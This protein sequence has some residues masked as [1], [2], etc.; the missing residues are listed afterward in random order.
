MLAP[1]NLFRCYL[2]EQ[3]PITR[4]KCCLHSQKY[5]ITWTKLVFDLSMSDIPLALKTL[6]ECE[7]TTFTS[8]PLLSILGGLFTLFKSITLRFFPTSTSLL[9]RLIFP[10]F[11]CF[12]VGQHIYFFYSIS[13]NTCAWLFLHIKKKMQFIDYLDQPW[14][15]IPLLVGLNVFLCRFRCFRYIAHHWPNTFMSLF[16]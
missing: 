16:H 6:G 3:F 12:L 9:P 11:F 13:S 5:V 4:Q 8:V 7:L 15:Y 2:T 14:L 10:N 1:I